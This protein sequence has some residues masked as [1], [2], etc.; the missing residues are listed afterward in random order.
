MVESAMGLSIGGKITNARKAFE[1]LKNNQLEDGSWYASYINGV[2]ED[3]THDTNMSSY[4]SVGIYHHYLI[5]GDP[6]YLAY[7]WPVIKKGINFALSLQTS[8]GEI[9]WAKSPE[10]IVDPTALLTGTSSI[11]MSV[12][13]AVEIGR[14]MNEDTSAWEE[15]MSMIQDAIK[16]RPHSF[17]IA[18]SRFSM[19]WFY[20]ILSGALTGDLAQKRLDKY[21]KKF[22]VEGQ[23]IRCVS[24]EPWVTVAETCE[25]VLALAAMGN[26]KL[27]NIFF[28]W[29]QG[30][31]YDDGSYWCGYT[32]PDM[33]IW[34]EDKLTWTNAV[35]LMAADALYGLTPG[36][37][38]FDHKYWK[39]KRQ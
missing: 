32:F 6:D 17:N 31:R 36:G 37:I 15:S 18:K 27:A 1:W 13:C 9:H 3:K 4:I 35:V 8:G 24:D 16:N 34:P 30:R 14:L 26:D 2:P 21:W 20:P 12:K 39:N 19:D 28:G 11:Y 10:G 25:F 38:L 5:T 7:M 23:G 29:I 33:I 22:V